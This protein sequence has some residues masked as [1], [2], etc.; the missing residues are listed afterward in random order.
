MKW[1]LGQEISG[2]VWFHER[3]G[4][5]Q[6]RIHT[7]KPQREEKYR[8]DGMYASSITKRHLTGYNK[9]SSQRSHA[10]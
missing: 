10:H 2:T 1:K 3:Q 9:K 5:D 8:K 7:K 6:R 4:N